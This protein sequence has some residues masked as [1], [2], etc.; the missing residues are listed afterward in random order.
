[1]AEGAPAA[2][3]AELAAPDRV[4]SAGA[5]AGGANPGGITCGA[6]LED[7]RDLPHD[8][9]RRVAGEGDAICQRCHRH[10]P[11][12]GPLGFAHMLG[13]AGGVPVSGKGA[14][15]DHAAVVQDPG[16]GGIEPP[17]LATRKLIA[18]RRARPDPK[19][20]ANRLGSR[21]GAR[22]RPPGLQR[23]AKSV[24]CRASLRTRPAGPAE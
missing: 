22:A 23:R 14:G 19:T 9:L 17:A 12:K 2:Q 6:N 20:G 21:L 10:P 7:Q 11:R 15:V 18:Q 16:Q 1:M 13:R 24:P 4:A 3:D 5:A 8:V